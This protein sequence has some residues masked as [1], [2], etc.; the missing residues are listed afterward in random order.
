MCE[1]IEPGPKGTGSREQTPEQAPKSRQHTQKVKT[2]GAQP[3]CPQ[4]CP[5]DNRQATG[6]QMPTMGSPPQISASSELSSQDRAGPRMPVRSPQERVQGSGQRV[7]GRTGPH[8]DA[9]QP[10]PRRSLSHCPDLHL[11]PPGGS[12]LATRPALQP[13]LRSISSAR[14]HGALL[15]GEG[16]RQGLSPQDTSSSGQTRRA[17]P[18]RNR[19]L[20][21]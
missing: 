5:G 11:Y 14:W 7:H 2:E 17:L 10:G 4:M 18:H 3:S 16:R 15:S 20:G 19:V 13:S 6:T 1:S 9:P 21:S 8:P 12:S